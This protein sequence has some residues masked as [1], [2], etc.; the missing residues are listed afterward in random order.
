MKVILAELFHD[1]PNVAN[2]DC[3]PQTVPLGIGYLASAL[4]TQ[5][6]D[7]NVPLFRSIDAFL[8][9]VKVQEPDLIGFAIN[10]WNLDLSKRA[11][12]LVRSLYPEVPIVAGG[13]CVDDDNEEFI[14]FL[15][16]YSAIDFVVPSEGEVGI[17]SLVQ[18]IRDKTS[19]YAPVKGVAYLSSNRRLTNQT[20][21][22]TPTQENS[23]LIQAQESQLIRGI[24]E[25]PDISTIKSPYLTGQ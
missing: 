19:F 23:T 15:S 7:V 22:S 18:A 25:K 4:S 17:V 6:S 8:K 2:I 11:I 10:S 1:N 20:D 13:P 3:T 14:T 21:S 12:D 24:Y 9:E 5:F 16:K